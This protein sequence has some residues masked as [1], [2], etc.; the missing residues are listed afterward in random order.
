ML[1]N[2]NSNVALCFLNGK[3]IAEAAG[4]VGAVREI[5][6]IILL[7]FDDDFEG[8]EFHIGWSRKWAP[9]V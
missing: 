8:V 6:D 9:W 4:D 2:G 1:F 5:P 3:T 7:F